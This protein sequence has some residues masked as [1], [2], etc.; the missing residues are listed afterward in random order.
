MP[1]AADDFAVPDPVEPPVG[2]RAEVERSRHITL[3]ERTALMWAKVRD[4]VVLAPDVEDSELA[5]AHPH[6]LVR[7]D[8]NLLDARDRELLLWSDASDL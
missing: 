7:A 3:A 6:H 8:R 2:V 5:S 4:R 1:R